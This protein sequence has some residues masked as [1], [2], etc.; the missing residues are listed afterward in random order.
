MGAGRPPGPLCVTKRGSRIDE[1]TL[2]RQ[3]SPTPGPLGIGPASS[4]LPDMSHHSDTLS[5]WGRKAGK[6]VSDVGDSAAGHSKSL[7][8]TV[9][10]LLPLKEESPFSTALLKHYV[11]RI[12]NAYELQNIPVPWQE[13]IVKATAGRAGKHADLNPYNSGLFDLRNSLGHFDV[14]V[15]PGST[16]K[17][18]KYLI[19]DTYQ[20]GF[21]PNDKAQRGRHGFPMG[22][23]TGWRLDAARK[24]LPS[25][26]YQNPGGFKE[27]WEIK[28]VGAETI[29]FIPQ[30]YLA[31]QGKPFPVSGV[32]ER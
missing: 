4:L 11:E 12:G 28:V 1:G 22:S 19:F 7:L 16:S 23:V 25:T 8:L 31:E 14:E 15:K 17:T 20:F 10:D 18:K 2:C 21:I 6:W 5:D 29:L 24:L 32:F 3:Q 30:Q 9:V 13:W 26:E 27:K